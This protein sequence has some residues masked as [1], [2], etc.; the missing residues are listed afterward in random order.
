MSVS[1]A[2][3]KAMLSQQTDEVFLTCLTLDHSS[4][5]VPVRV[6][7]DVQALVRTAGTFQPFLFEIAL[8]NDEEGKPP[9]VNLKISNVDR[10]IVDALK[11][12]PMNEFP[13]VKMEVVMA[14]S[15]DTVEAGPF[16]M[17]LMKWS[18]DA[19]VV[20]GKL[21]YQNPLNDAFPKD[22]MTPSTTPGLF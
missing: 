8:P 3:L 22:D 12:L 21:G 15:P 13:T 19:G 20:T 14:S 4:M 1:P 16:V 18:A 6:V 17:D 5:S 7:N 10:A 9:T 2:A 11:D